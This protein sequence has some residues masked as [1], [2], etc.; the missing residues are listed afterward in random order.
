MNRVHNDLFNTVWIEVMRNLNPGCM[1][2]SDAVSNCQFIA[3]IAKIIGS[4]D[5]HIGIFSDIESWK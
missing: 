1:W 5:K 2:A 3:E 4:K